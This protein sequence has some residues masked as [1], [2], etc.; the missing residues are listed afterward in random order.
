MPSSQKSG[1]AAKRPVSQSWRPA[2]PP[3][4]AAL[5]LRRLIRDQQ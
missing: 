2:R 4:P 3:S 1:C 5:H